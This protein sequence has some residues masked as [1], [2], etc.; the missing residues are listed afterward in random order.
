MGERMARVAVVA[1]HP[2][3]YQAPWLRALARACDLEV[4]FC[5]RQDAVGQG[6]AGFGNE[7]EWDIPLTEG[8]AHRWL[9]NVSAAPSV[10]R[11]GGCDTPGVAAELARGRFDACIVNGW[12]LKSYVQ[13]IR[14]CARIGLPVLVRGDS[15]LAGPRRPLTRTVKYLPYRWFLRRVDGHLYVGTRNREY[16]EHYGVPAAKLFFAPHA[17]DNVWFRS[18]VERARS[19]GRVSGLREALGIPVDAEV[20]LYAGKLIEKKRPLDF[21]DGLALLS[22]AQPRVRGV[23]VG[24]GPLEASVRERASAHGVDVAFAG[25]RNQSEMPACYGMAD[26]L[27]LP[28]DGRETWG[29][30]VNEAMAC[31]VPAAVSAEAGS[32]AD[33]PDGLHSGISFACGDV[34][35][36]A[37]AVTRLLDARRSRPT[38][39]RAALERKLRE[40]SIERAVAGALEAIEAT[41]TPGRAGQESPAWS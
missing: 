40:F 17:V 37:D 29:L 34:H 15:Q 32:A 36:L 2:V 27:V 12:Y 31:G 10:D 11:F 6:A 1:S 41:G 14:A 35:G 7:F 39:V 33:L 21:I 9:T 3:Q 18:E 8:F 13:A 30:V 5:H 28:S 16:L 23:V 25:F 24:T 26:V 22:A 4:L 19:E 38:Q 20:V